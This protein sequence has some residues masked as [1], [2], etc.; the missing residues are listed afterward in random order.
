MRTSLNY[1]RQ[2]LSAF[3]LAAS[4]LALAAACSAQ[5]TRPGALH[6]LSIKAPATRILFQPRLSFAN[7]T[8]TLQGTGFFTIGPTGQTLAI[9]SAHYL[10]FKGPALAKMEWLDIVSNE[11]IAT[12]TT[13]WGPPGNA[14]TTL[15]L[16]LRNDYLIMPVT[17]TVQTE[18]VLELDDRT[19]DATER[20][21]LPNKSR[22]AIGFTL[23]EGTVEE[24]GDGYI[25]VILDQ[26]I[27]LTSQS[28]SPVISQS[29]GKVIGLVSR[30]G[31]ARTS[32]TA[33]LLAPVSSI[34]QTIGTK[35]QLMPLR[36][37]IGK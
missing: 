22:S 31:P 13:S 14:G 35:Q 32:R 12:M 15:P 18:S 16:D 10:N 37:V 7:G 19:V 5:D 28:G 6:K 27:E 36:K 11:T 17:D 3:L 25:T 1:L 9:T 21:W 8:E 29:T 26:S 2:P 20:I 30:R 24:A 23:V 33:L 34:R 4:L